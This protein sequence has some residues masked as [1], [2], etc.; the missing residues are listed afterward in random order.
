MNSKKNLP[1]GY[2]EIL[3]FIE[4]CDK[5]KLP[6]ILTTNSL[7]EGVQIFLDKCYQRRLSVNRSL[8]K[9]M[10]D[11]AN[12]DHKISTVAMVLSYCNPT[13]TINDIVTFIKT[14]KNSDK[15]KRKLLLVLEKFEE[16]DKIP[17]LISYFNDKEWLAEYALNSMLTYTGQNGEGIGEL[18]QHLVGLDKEFYHTL[19]ANLAHSTEEQ[20]IWILGLLAEFYDNTVAEAAIK[21]LGY[22]KS[23]IAYEILENLIAHAKDK[24]ELKN[25]SMQ[26]LSQSGIVKKNH[27]MLIPHKCYLSW[28]DANGSRI[29]LV[30]R[31]TGRGRLFMVTF[32]LNEDYGIHDCSVWNDISIFE[33][34]SIVKGLEKQAGLKQIDYSLVITIVEDAIW[35]SM[36]KKK[37]I[38]PTF[39]F[40]RRIFG[41]QKLHPKKYNIDLINIGIEYVNK[42]RGKLLQ[43]SEELIEEVPFSEWWLDTPEAY[44]FVKKRKSLLNGKKL[45]K[46]SVNQFVK[47]IIEKNKNK[48]ENRFLMSAD[49]FHRT[50]PRMYRQT[51]EIC[52]AIHISIKEG[53]AFTSI[54]FMF[55]LAE[56]SI[57]NIKDKINSET[58]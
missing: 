44:E 35:K 14:P 2:N 21:A 31:R 47:N 25:K 4:T 57:R 56:L 50:S 30:S 9:I 19:T 24:E 28:I 7:E 54:P 1:R 46:D 6:E 15:V 33:M 10:E 32:I 29:L 18:F 20:S 49:F 53:L 52:L 48:W 27:R 5:K 36:Q 26:K 23:P 40:A 41:S 45:R 13:K 37:L 43:E 42:K 51:I 22:K 12:N 16:F 34:D 55:K 58:Q 11:F 38:T 3:D 17:K 39:L 8:L